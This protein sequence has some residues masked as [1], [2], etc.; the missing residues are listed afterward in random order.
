MNGSP[1]T[2]YFIETVLRKIEI[3]QKSPEMQRS[4]TFPSSIL[5]FGHAPLY[6]NKTFIWGNNGLENLDHLELASIVH[7]YGT[8]FIIRTYRY[9]SSMGG[10]VYLSIW[11][12]SDEWC[13][14]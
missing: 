10:K 1:P 6:W 9:G 2:F 5:T 7:C 13:G 11:Q 14:N 12:E 4:S 3:A 8:F